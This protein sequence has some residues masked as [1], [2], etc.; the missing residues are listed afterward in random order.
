MAGLAIDA[1]GVAVIVLGIVAASARFALALRSLPDPYRRLRHDLGRAV[2]LGL[3]FLVAADI[4]RTVALAPTIQ[5]GLALGLI[6]LIR[7]FLSLAME[8]EI[9]G[10]WPW[11]RARAARDGDARP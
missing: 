5:N 4:I 6:V 8:V 3:E 10:E 9:E 1:L 11:K 2:L 7:T